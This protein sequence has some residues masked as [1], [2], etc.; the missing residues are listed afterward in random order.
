MS[1]TVQDVDNALGQ[2]DTELSTAV[3]NEAQEVSLTQQ[4]ITD[5]QALAAKVSPD[6]TPEVNHILQQL[7]SLQSVA[8]NQATV[9]QNVVTADD[10]AGG[11]ETVPGT[12]APT[13][14]TPNS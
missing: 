1:D 14:P 3:A 10:A 4:L 11:T 2:M 9:E 6:L 8:D 13:P 7:Q 12:P 5:V